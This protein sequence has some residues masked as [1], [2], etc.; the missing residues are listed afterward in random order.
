MH[1]KVRQSARG[2][3]PVAQHSIYRFLDATRGD[4]AQTIQRLTDA[5][6]WRRSFGIEG[7]FEDPEVEEEVSRC[8]VY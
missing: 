8:S 6:I 3:N 4:L 1:R 7:L 2:I 5:L